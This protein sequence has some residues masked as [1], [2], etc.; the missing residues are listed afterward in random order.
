MSL[1]ALALTGLLLI[2]TKALD[3]RSTWLHVGVE[4]EANPLVRRWFQGYGLARGLLAA[5][6][7]YL[8]VLAAE[9]GLVAWL[10]QPLLTW[11]SVALGLFVAWA[12]WDVARFNSTRKHSWF[13]RKVLR[14][15]QH[16]GRS[17]QHGNSR[18][19]PHH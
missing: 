6:A 18:R 11:G 5:S 4:G 10:D 16:W 12:Q 3:V 13:T 17:C 2:A 7:L 14:I 9:L 19:T 1:L 15:Y 8:L